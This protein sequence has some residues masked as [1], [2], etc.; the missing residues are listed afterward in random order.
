MPNDFSAA[1]RKI[2]RIYH[3]L[4]YTVTVPFVDQC[5]EIK[6]FSNRMFEST[7]RLCEIFFSKEVRIFL[8]KTK[9]YDF[10]DFCVVWCVNIKMARKNIRRRRRKKI[11]ATARKVFRRWQNSVAPVTT[12]GDGTEKLGYIGEDEETKFLF[13]G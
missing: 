10:W 5:S 4:A 12:F 7:K 1:R 9:I 2:E 11:P 8:S 3:G 6:K 13:G